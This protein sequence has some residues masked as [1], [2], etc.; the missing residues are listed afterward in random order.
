VSFLSYAR[1]W[2]NVIS[3]DKI[4]SPSEL[5]GD[6]T[7]LLTEIKS[8]SRGWDQ[9]V[10][11]NSQINFTTILNSPSLGSIIQNQWSILHMG[12]SLPKVNTRLYSETCHF[13]ASLYF[14]I[15]IRLHVIYIQV[16]EH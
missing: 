3:T 6:L 5:E 13:S 8:A 7:Y 14:W 4:V 12:A 10:P 15:G 11:K 1:K 9:F 16:A 2:I